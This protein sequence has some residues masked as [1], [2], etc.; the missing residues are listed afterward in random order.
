MKKMSAKGHYRRTGVLLAGGSTP[1]TPNQHICPNLRGDVQNRESAGPLADGGHRAPME[2]MG[3]RETSR[4]SLSSLS[5]WPCC[6]VPALALRFSRTAVVG[7]A[8]RFATC[9]LAM[10]AS[11]FF[12]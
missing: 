3:V 5:G 9:R 8:S 1:S 6:P 10:A 12:V 11:F 2:G 7:L 4:S